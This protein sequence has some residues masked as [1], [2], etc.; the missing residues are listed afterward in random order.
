ML[1]AYQLQSPLNSLAPVC[2]GQDILEV[3]KQVAQVQGQ[4]AGCR[5]HS[6]VGRR[7]S[8]P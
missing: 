2:A 8:P 7:H 5:L 1:T 4:P 6:V 3:Q